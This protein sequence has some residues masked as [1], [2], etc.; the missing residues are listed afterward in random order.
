M[1]TNMLKTS[2]MAYFGEFKQLQERE[3]DV[4][5]IF[6]DNQHMDFTNKEILDELRIHEPELDINSVTGRVHR[7]RGKGKN[8]PYQNHPHLIESIVRPCKITGRNV[9]AWQLNNR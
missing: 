3:K 4:I 2:L 8:N 6:R 7:L 1:R 5:R 9:N